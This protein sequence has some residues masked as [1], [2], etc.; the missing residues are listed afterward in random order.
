MVSVSKR[1]GVLGAAKVDGIPEDHARTEC[2]DQRVKTGQKWS[3]TGKD[4]SKPVKNVHRPTRQNTGQN[5]H[6]SKQSLVKTVNG[7]N[8]HWSKQS[9]VKKVAE[10]F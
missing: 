6:W 1:Q 4:W 10:P 7:Q 5:S 3:T 2:F 8:S 9:L